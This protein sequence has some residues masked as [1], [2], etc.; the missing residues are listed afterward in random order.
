MPLDTERQ[1]EI[2]VELLTRPGHE[3]VRS[4]VY[5]LLVQGLG[6]TSEQVRFEEQ[7]REVHGR[8]DALLGLT[9]FEFNGVI[10]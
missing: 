10:E 2:V 8:T 7:L 5:D 9:L 4:L 1:Q 6:A 3:K